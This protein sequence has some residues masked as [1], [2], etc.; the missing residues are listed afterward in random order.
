MTTEAD[1]LIALGRPILDEEQMHTFVT[2]LLPKFPTLQDRVSLNEI[3]STV[4]AV[5]SKALML[6][7]TINAREANMEAIAAAAL[8]AEAAEN[9]ERVLAAR[10]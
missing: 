9:R 4:G 10:L 1:D 7:E 5:L 6:E 2:G 8:V 3:T